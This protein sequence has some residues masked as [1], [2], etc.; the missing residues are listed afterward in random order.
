MDSNRVRVKICGITRVE[1]AIAAADA[2]ADAIGL[3]FYPRSKRVIDISRAK[4]II[5]ALPP[6]ITT[7]GLFVDQDS[8]YIQSLVKELDLDL[9]QFHGDESQEECLAISKPYIKAI[10]M[11]PGIDLKDL[12]LEYDSC[13]G[14]LLDA[15]VSGLAGG[16][17]TSFEWDRVPQNLQKPVILAG[18]LNPENVYDAVQVVKPYAVDVSGGVE[19]EPGIKDSS[20]IIEFIKNVRLAT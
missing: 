20:K 5:K 7:V 19:S 14:I 10:R 8:A 9:L 16:T 12:I 11:K 1:D 2:G 3:N 18:G 4:A 17:G 15:Y 6:F 13:S